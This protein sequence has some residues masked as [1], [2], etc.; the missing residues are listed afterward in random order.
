MVND[1]LNAS[2]HVLFL[3]VHLRLVSYY[4]SV[5]TAGQFYVCS[6][7]KAEAAEQRESSK[8]HSALTS[9]TTLRKENDELDKVETWQF[10]MSSKTAAP[11]SKQNQFIS[12][13][14]LY[15]IH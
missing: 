13:K 3:A 14:V 1:I 10:S 12:K 6:C 5:S 9:K 2:F 4:S 8:F 7:G 11:G 15:S